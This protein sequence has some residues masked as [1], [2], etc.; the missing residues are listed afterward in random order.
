MKILNWSSKPRLS[1]I[2]T[3]DLLIR[4]VTSYDPS[5]QE[6]LAI[7]MQ[8]Q[9]GKPTNASQS[10]ATSQAATFGNAL[11]SL[12]DKVAESHVVASIKD[13]AAKDRHSLFRSISFKMPGLSR[14]KERLI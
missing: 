4:L 3:L 5:P 13:E 10:M 8:Q 1:S 6:L 9:N 11:P 14:S 7:V 2:H 12:P